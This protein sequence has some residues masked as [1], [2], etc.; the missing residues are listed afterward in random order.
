MVLA[1]SGTLRIYGTSYCYSLQT[2][3]TES[4]VAQRV[5]QCI[6]IHHRH[7]RVPRRLAR[8]IYGAG[9]VLRLI[10][11]LLRGVHWANR[12]TRCQRTAS[13]YSL[14]LLIYATGKLGA[15]S[16]YTVTKDSHVLPWVVGH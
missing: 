2:N 14:T 16:Y 8:M 6:T 1:H 4:I 13:V 10:N 7:K 11:V 3:R 9:D 15:G 12:R 5:R